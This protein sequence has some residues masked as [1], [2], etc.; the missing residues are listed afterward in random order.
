[1]A[2]PFRFA[3]PGAPLGHY[4]FGVGV[5]AGL[6]IG[7]GAGV[8]AGVGVD[9]TGVEAGEATGELSALGEGDGLAL[10]VLPFVRA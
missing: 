4:L 7:V 8:G 6:D 10:A 2:G 9:S 3:C 1:M 5:V